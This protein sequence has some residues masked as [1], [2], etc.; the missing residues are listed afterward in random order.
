MLIQRLVTSNPSRGYIYRVAQR[1]VQTSGNLGEVIKAIL[2]D[3]EA[4]SLPLLDNVTF[5]KEK[6]P[7]IRYVA[8]LR[9]LGGTSKMPLA[10]LVPY[11]YPA[12]ELAKF[13]TGAS[14]Y[15][16]ST[17]DTDL[18]QSPL[19]APTVF[20]WFLPDYAPGGAVAAAG[21]VAPEFQITSESQVIAAINYH[22]QVSYST[23]GQSV[24]SLPIYLSTDDDVKNDLAPFY[25]LYDNA[26]AAKLTVTDAVTQV[27]D[28]FDQLLCAGHLKARYAAA[29]VP[30]PRRTIIDTVVSTSP[31]SSTPTSN[32]V[33]TAL[34]LVLTAPEFIIQK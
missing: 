1:W 28:A 33:R 7:I 15:R 27:V 24:S 4:R 8:T 34:Y 16:Y 6:E 13:P 20:N 3:Y 18:G 21:L 31:T 32:R 9:A 26:I 30:N 11:G 10:D 22:Y 12:A 2:L 19:R 17:T 25:A 29:T 14:V 23:S 5:G